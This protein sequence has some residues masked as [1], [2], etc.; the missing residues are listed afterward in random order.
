M[1]A[2]KNP[3]SRVPYRESA[4]TSVLRKSLGRRCRTVLIVTLSVDLENLA[5]TVTACR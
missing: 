5:E 2:L 1:L 3:G 4:L